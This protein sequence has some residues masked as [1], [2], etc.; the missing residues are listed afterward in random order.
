MLCFSL[1]FIRTDNKTFTHT[2]TYTQSVEKKII[3]NALLQEKNY[4]K[5]KKSGFTTH[6]YSNHKTN[7]LNSGKV[8]PFQHNEVRHDRVVKTNTHTQAVT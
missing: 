4:E 5:N 3:T 7:G 1:N 2:H 8:F 6:Y